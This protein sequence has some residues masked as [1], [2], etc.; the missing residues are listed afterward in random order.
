[1]KRAVDVSLAG[2]G[3][4][5]LAPVIASV[6]VAVR[7]RLGTP[8]LLRQQRAGLRGAPF[9]IL[10]FRT[11]TQGRDTS[12]QL[13]P[14]EERLTGFGSFLRATSL[15]E[16]PELVNVL[17]GEMS[18]VGPRPLLLQYVPLYSA[19]QR[20]RLEVR[21]GITGLAQISGRNELSWPAKLALDVAYVDRWSF[22]L[23]LRI[24]ALTIFHTIAR[25]GISPRGMATPPLFR[26]EDA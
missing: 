9:V 8:V 16:L 17:R 25:H 14:D 3:L 2:I 7:L 22:W 15:D 10:K 6:A 5:L 12:G 11:M 26:G 1:M 21:P 18:L 13:L 24:L 20:R 23:D 19:Q 4:T